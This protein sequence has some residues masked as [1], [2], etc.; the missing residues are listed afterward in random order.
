MLIAM[1][2]DETAI[3]VYGDKEGVVII[4]PSFGTVPPQTAREFAAA[5][6]EGANEAERLSGPLTLHSEPFKITED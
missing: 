1:G 2:A 6:L 5:L 4:F 3:E